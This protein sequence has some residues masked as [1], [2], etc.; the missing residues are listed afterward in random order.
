MP[1]Y[2]YI[3][4]NSVGDLVVDETD[5]LRQAMADHENGEYELTRGKLPI[6]LV[7]YNRFIDQKEARRQKE[8]I[9]SWSTKDK[10]KLISVSGWKHEFAVAA[11]TFLLNEKNELLLCLHADRGLWMLPGGGVDPGEDAL[12]AAVREATEE[13]GLDIRITRFAG[14]SDRLLRKQVRICFQGEV[15]GGEFKKNKEVSEIRWF[16]LDSLPDDM[17][18]SSKEHIDAFIESPDRPF[19][20]SQHKHL[21]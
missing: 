15:T 13:T 3:V 10:H 18:R 6:H 12:G 19:F 8:E 16:P 14:M 7:F 20:F 9:S 21:S 4:E 11:Y 17:V 2:V 5:D 1:H